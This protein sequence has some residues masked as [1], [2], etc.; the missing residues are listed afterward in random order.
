MVE[1]VRK[2]LILIFFYHLILHTQ[3]KDISPQSLELEGRFDK[4]EVDNEQEN[5]PQKQLDKKDKKNDLFTDPNGN[6]KFKR[7]RIDKDI[8]H[9]LFIALALVFKAVCLIFHQQIAE[10]LK[11]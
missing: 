10:Y 8:K 1:F 6:M 7:F 5:K 2:F 3:Q 11:L 4:K 9:G